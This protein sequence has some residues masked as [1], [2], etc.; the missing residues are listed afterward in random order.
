MV[1]PSIHGKRDDFSSL[2]CFLVVYSTLGWVLSLQPDYLVWFNVSYP[3][4][5]VYAHT[6]Y[7]LTKVYFMGMILSRGI[8]ADCIACNIVQI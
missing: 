2:L 5:I 7:L 1:V 6:L 3:T 8:F 4:D